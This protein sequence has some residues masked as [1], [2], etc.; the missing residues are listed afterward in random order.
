MSSTV[1][2]VLETYVF[3]IDSMIGS[4]DI[5]TFRHA[6]FVRNEEI[7]HYQ[8]IEYLHFVNAV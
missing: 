5:T 4:Y 7:R 8:P 2:H 1:I 6:V 3:F